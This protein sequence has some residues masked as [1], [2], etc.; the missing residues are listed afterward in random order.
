MA[1]P[2][3]QQIAEARNRGIVPGARIRCASGE[4]EGYVSPA[5]KWDRW[6]GGDGDVFFSCGFDD[7]GLHL[8]ADHC[9]KQA[10]V[11]AAPTKPTQPRIKGRF[12]AKS[13]PRKRATKPKEP[14]PTDQP[15]TVYSLVC[16]TNGRIIAMEARI[17]K[18]IKEVYNTAKS[19]NIG[20]D[21]ALEAIREV[22][23]TLSKNPTQL[24]R[25]ETYLN[26]VGQAVIDQGR[27]F[28][29]KLSVIE[30]SVAVIRSANTLLDAM[31]KD[32]ADGKFE[33]PQVDELQ[34]F[35][36][37]CRCS[38]EEAQEL[39]QIAENAG[40]RVSDVDGST[41]GVYL[42]Q[43][44]FLHQIHGNSFSE[45]P[46]PFPE[47]RRRLLGTIARRKE[48]ELAEKVKAL[49]FG[50]RVMTPDGEGVYSCEVVAEHHHMVLPKGW[51]ACKPFHV[52]DI[53]IL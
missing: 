25:I 46:I 17:I 14:A 22:R 9:G 6:I 16:E 20:A 30:S 15:V 52:D 51:T 39:M 43:E 18:R 29:S 28:K 5:E 42:Y 36:D 11:I 13:A 10:I 48:A 47:F 8:Y 3:E 23:A 50:V 4:G 19:A 34:V 24:D 32:R 27:E 40:M 7:D 33:A 21:N 53:Q 2:T 41:G 45:K 38:L 44:N 35:I 31:D 12:A 1:K 26:K 37:Q 49:K